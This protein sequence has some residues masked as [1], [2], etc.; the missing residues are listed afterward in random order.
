MV[1][2]PM[3]TETSRDFYGYVEGNGYQA[4]D[5][6]YSSGEMS[7]TI[8]LPDRGTVPRIRRFAERTGPGPDFRRP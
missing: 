1:E 7:M 6:P 5:V 3:M 8:L 2:A 4:V